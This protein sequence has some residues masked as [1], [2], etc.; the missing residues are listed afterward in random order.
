MLI[1]TQPQRTQS[2]LL[3]KT[4]TDTQHI[5]RAYF[6]RLVLQQGKS[7]SSRNSSTLSSHFYSTATYCSASANQLCGF[8]SLSLIKRFKCKKRFSLHPRCIFILLAALPL[9]ARTVLQ[10]HQ[11]I[12]W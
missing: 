1:A 12:A 2:N 11:A 8:G 6:P 4:C 3:L 5:L 7:D 9:F 10:V